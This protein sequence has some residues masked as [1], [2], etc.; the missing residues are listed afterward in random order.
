MNIAQV[1]GCY[2]ENLLKFDLIL[3]PYLFEEEKLMTNPTKGILVQEVEKELSADNHVS[4][5]NWELCQ[6]TFL[7]DVMANFRKMI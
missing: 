4:P 6:S 7:V 1:R 2:L 3:S 5:T